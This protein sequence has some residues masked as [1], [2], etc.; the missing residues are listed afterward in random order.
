MIKK[1]YTFIVTEMCQLN[2][3]YCYLV[4]K[5]DN[6]KM[7]LEVATKAVDY[8]FSE[9][10]LQDSEEVVFDFIGG[11]PLLEIELISNI[12]NYI[13]R[14]M[15]SNSHKWQ[16]SYEIRLTTNGLLYGHPLV[17]DF[18]NQHKQHLSISISIDGNKTKNDKNRVYKNGMGS[19]DY[20]IDNVRLW[21]KQFPNVGTKMTI[22]HED[23]PY[24]SEGLKHLIDLGIKT[25][26]V[27]PVVE[28]VWKENDE[29]TFQEQLINVADYIIENNLWEQVQISCFDSYIGH[30]IE[31]SQQL[32]PCGAMSLSID[33]QGNF[34]SCIR[35]A[36]YSLRSKK[37]IVI[38]D[39]YQGLDKNKLRTLDLYFNNVVSEDS[40]LDCE[41]ASGCKWCPAE[42]YDSS[43]IG[44][45]YIRTTYSCNIHKAKV[46]AK[47]YYFNLLKTKGV[48][49]D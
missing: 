11:E 40:C 31:K 6:N 35:F 39:I 17:Q 32:S 25:I 27:N 28:D 12:M 49:Y 3:K 15:E 7:T 45:M 34:Y 8:I 30:P 2:C 5:N 24:V 38:G 29:F 22:S 44:S 42:S 37:P 20:I 47:N 4:G 26:D 41:V 36:A 43:E 48:Y 21:I 16:N 13:L 1:T 14:K 18:I 46:R 23:I 33:P 19:Y 10:T 9:S